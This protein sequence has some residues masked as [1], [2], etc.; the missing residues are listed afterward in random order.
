MV[1]VEDCV[2]GACAEACAAAGD[3]GVL[4]LENVRFHKAEEGKGC[5]PAERKAFEEELSKL[6]DVFINDAFGTAH[7]AHASM[8]GVALP[9]KCAGLLLKKELD[10]FAKALESPQKP[11]LAILG[12]AKVADK[13]QLIRNLLPLVDEMII[14]GGMAFTFGTYC[15]QRCRKCTS[16]NHF[17][18]S[19]KF[20]TLLNYVQ[21]RCWTNTTLAI[22]CLTRKVPKLSK[23]WRLKQRKQMSRFIV[24]L[25]LFVLTS[26]Q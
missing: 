1:F 6:G 17:L 24:Q 2:G 16:L 15:L 21:P 20:L 3:G 9:Q 23:N 19:L 13:I 12:G 18:F 22:L 7:R 14:G 10:Y 25:I 11:F 4:L 26:L 5:E 8:V